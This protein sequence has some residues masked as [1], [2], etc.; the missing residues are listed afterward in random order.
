MP[1]MLAA[2]VAPDTIEAASAV[3][4]VVRMVADDVALAVCDTPLARLLAG[5]DKAFRPSV[6]RVFRPASNRV[7][8]RPAAAACSDCIVD[9]PFTRLSTKSDANVV[10]PVRIVVLMVANVAFIRSAAA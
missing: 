3:P 6:T 7:L 9:S 4:A 10:A 1:K 5:P 8:P 2:S